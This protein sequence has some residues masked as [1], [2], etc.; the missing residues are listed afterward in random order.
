MTEIELKYPPK[1]RLHASFILIRS[2]HDWLPLC[3]TLLSPRRISRF[4]EGSLPPRGP[5]EPIQPV[6]TSASLKVILFALRECVQAL[7]LLADLPSATKHHQQQ[8]QHH[9]TQCKLQSLM[10]ADIGSKEH[11]TSSVS[12]ETISTCE[13]PW[14][15]SPRC[16]YSGTIHSNFQD[17]HTLTQSRC[18]GY[19]HP[20]LV[21]YLGIK[22]ACMSAK[23][24]WLENLS[25]T[26][27]GLYT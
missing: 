27:S 19:V 11:Q 25:G 18:I 2:H 6:P 4:F 10:T 14:S 13:I 7:E 22:A 23:G 26:W 8:N 17:V 20:N 12:I 1:P 3:S 21:S 16:S 9:Q 24:A 15:W 5:Y